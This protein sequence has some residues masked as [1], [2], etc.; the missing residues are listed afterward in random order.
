MFL[1]IFLI[2]GAIAT[3]ST[4]PDVSSEIFNDSSAGLRYRNQH[5]PNGD[6]TN[7]QIQYRVDMRMAIPLTADGKLKVKARILTANTY[8]GS[9]N[10]AG[11]GNHTKFQD[12]L[13]VRQFYLEYTPNGFVTIETGAMGNNTPGLAS[14]T[15]LSPDG[16]GWIDGARAT[17]RTGSKENLSIEQM[18]VT[19]GRVSDLNKTNFY[20]RNWNTDPNFVQV[21]LKGRINKYVSVTGQ[22]TQIEETNYLR[23]IVELATKDLV[24]FVDK[25]VI[26]DLI[27]GQGRAQQ[28]FALGAQKAVGAWSFVGE[29]SFKSADIGKAGPTNL[30][31]EDFYKAGHQVTFSVERSLPK[32]AGKLYVKAGKTVNG[33]QLGSLN[34]ARV[35]GGYKY[36]FKHKKK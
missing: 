10:N 17:Y 24:S 15:P 36:T 27:R 26:E 14:G 22:A 11:V 16:D 19:V 20:D 9:W 12:D 33:T 1:N 7:N 34:G 4:P 23:G 3:A 5:K 13:G 2:A 28:G 21:D 25:V 32:N 31:Y 18:S 8:D 30:M 35:E 6:L 29:Y